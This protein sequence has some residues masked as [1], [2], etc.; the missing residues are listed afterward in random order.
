VISSSGYANEN[1][2]IRSSLYDEQ[3]SHSELSSIHN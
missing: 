2:S 3:D 1:Q